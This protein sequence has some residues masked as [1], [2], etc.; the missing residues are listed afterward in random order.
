MLLVA[1]ASGGFN[2]ASRRNGLADNRPELIAPQRLTSSV[3]GFGRDA[4]NDP[5][6][7]GAT[8]FPSVRL[9][10]SKFIYCFKRAKFSLFMRA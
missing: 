10:F 5:L 6:D 1:P 2:S 8:S 9:R 3:A 7:A 4:R